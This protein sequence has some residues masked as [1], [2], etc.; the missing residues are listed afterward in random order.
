MNWLQCRITIRR[1]RKFG[2]T[3][4]R[5]WPGRFLTCRPPDAARQNELRNILNYLQVDCPART[6][7]DLSFI[8]GKTG[9]SFSAL[10][11][12][13]TP[14]PMNDEG[15]DSHWLRHP[16]AHHLGVAIK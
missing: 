6:A 9:H 12:A 10:A 13:A 2:L 11:A 14:C 8:G 15:S 5:N 7:D 3:R 4:P 16:G 1:S